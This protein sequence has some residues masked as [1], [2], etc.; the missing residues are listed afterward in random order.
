MLRRIAE[1]AG[2]RFIPEPLLETT[3]NEVGKALRA[4]RCF[5][6]RIDDG[7]FAQVS[8]EYLVPGVA[9][10]GVGCDIVTPVAYSA[11]Q[12]SAT[13]SSEDTL[14]DPRFA[15]A[16]SQQIFKEFGVRAAVVSPVIHEG[17]TLGLLGVHQC[18]DKRE[19]SPD[20]LELLETVTT[21]LAMCLQ[22]CRVFANQ[23]AQSEVLAQMN[24]DLSR[25]Y[26]ELAGKDAQIAKFMHLISHDFRSPVVAIRGLVDLLKKEY[27]SQPID[28]KPRRYLELI[29]HSTEQ[30]THL[31]GALLEFARLGQS[32]LS[33]SEVN[34]EELVRGIW[35]RC[36]VNVPDV[37][38]EI[39]GTLPVVRADRSRLVQIFQ[40]LIE[41]A[42]KYRNH[43]GPLVVDVSCQETDGFWQF[44]VIDNG[45]GFHP[46]EAE[47]LFDLFVRLKEVRTKPGS[48]I[49]LAS[50]MEI[51]RLHG[52]TAWAAGRPGKGATF[53]FTISK[54]ILDKPVVAP[55]KQL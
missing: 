55:T 32:S 27:E 1:A 13:V 25:L 33:L 41:N 30:V 23:Q 3:V 11:R 40:N 46:S 9:A 21:L 37:K 19:W 49:G 24:E 22:S 43:S 4:S 29:L 31:T 44:A 39:F 34:T 53:H 47:R 36:S 28:S 50:V 10:I 38:L 6:Y 17:M 12:S 42:I 7:G 51:A 5:F 45:V 20:E 15:E 14:N 2:R 26:V 52:G 35:Q 8:H 48:G 16:M 18:D 54:N